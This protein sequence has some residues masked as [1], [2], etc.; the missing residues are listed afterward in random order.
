MISLCDQMAPYIL[1]DLNLYDTRAKFNQ[2]KTTKPWPA[3]Q[4][5]QASLIKA[6]DMAEEL[7]EA[8]DLTTQEG[9]LT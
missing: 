7:I 9:W 3:F 5:A 4:T 8:G 2:H 1:F 6:I